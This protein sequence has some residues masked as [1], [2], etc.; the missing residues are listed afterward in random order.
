VKA[1]AETTGDGFLQRLTLDA[2]VDNG[3]GEKVLL[4]LPGENTIQRAGVKLAFGNGPGDEWTGSIKVDELST[5][6]FASKSVEILL[7]GLAQNIATPAERRV[8]FT[9]TG[10]ASAVTASRADIAE[11]LGDRVTIDI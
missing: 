1:A 8:T 11:A 10:G 9:A 2:N 4:P 7:S 3:T 5:S 6:T